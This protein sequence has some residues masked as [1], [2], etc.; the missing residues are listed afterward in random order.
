MLKKTLRELSYHSLIYLLGGLASSFASIALLPVYTRYLSPEDYGVIEVI[1]SMRSLLIVVLL[2]G[3]VPAMAKFFQTNDDTKNREEVVVTSLFFVLSS[4][5]L[6]SAILFLCND[7]IS[8]KI[9]GSVDL[10]YFVNLG[11]TLLFLQA[12]LTTGETYLNIQKQSKKF[13]TISLTK[14]SL[15]I[16]ANLY[17]IIWCKMGAKGMLIGEL[18]STGAVAGYLLINIVSNNQLSIRLPLLKKMLLFGLPFIPNTL[19]ASL[20]HRV[21]R[22]LLAEFTSLAAIGI[23]GLG[24]RFPF[25]LNFLLLGSFGRIWNSSIMYEIERQD[26]ALANYSKIAK[27]FITLYVFSQFALAVLAPSIVSILAAPDYYEAW[28]VVQ[29]VALGMCFYSLHQFFTI[30]AFTKSKTWLLLLPYLLSAIVNIV[31]NYYLLPRFGYLAAA[32]STVITYFIFSVSSYFIFR[33]ILPVPFDILKIISLFLMAICLVLLNN[34]FM[35]DSFTVELLKE[36][37]ILVL[38]P[39]ILIKSPYF[40]QNEKGHLRETAINFHPTLGKFV[41]KALR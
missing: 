15:N 28:K 3:F 18:L 17:F 5:F 26:D 25:M 36:L 4:A 24:Y 30:G 14:L 27:Y 21:D 39:L 11:T 19:C 13:L 9:F 2:A 40:D 33:K 29:I 12:I 7:T 37:S 35:T 34:F 10:V 6:W 20:M 16:S 1:D 8:L 31:L 23:Y 38:L 32:W 41:Q 22:Y